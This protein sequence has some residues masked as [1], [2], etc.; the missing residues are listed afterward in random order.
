MMP[1]Q[2][3][4]PPCVWLLPRSW[5]RGR[6][7]WLRALTLTGCVDAVSGHGVFLHSVGAGGERREAGHKGAQHQNE[8]QGCHLVVER[9]WWSDPG[10]GGAATLASPKPVGEMLS[11]FLRKRPEPTTHWMWG[12]PPS[13]EEVEG[14][15][16]AI[17]ARC[18]GTTGSAGK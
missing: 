13:P 17:S 4:A 1:T 14:A 10:Q 15:A 5:G 7:A 18:R 12:V 6:V 11:I 8:A 3:L 16:Q 9:E 2:N